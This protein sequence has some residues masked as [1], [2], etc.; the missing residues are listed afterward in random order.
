MT[1]HDAPHPPR[2]RVEHRQS[3]A[4]PVILAETERLI[5]AAEVLER[6]RRWLATA[7]VRGTLAIIC[8]IAAAEIL[9]IE[10]AIDLSG[11]L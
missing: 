4:D 1:T 7:G 9:V 2:F 11:F 10:R 6:H 8:Q 5:D 3:H